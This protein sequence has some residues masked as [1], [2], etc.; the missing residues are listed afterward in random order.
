[1]ARAA[2][3]RELY[4]ARA[5]DYN[6]GMGVGW[7]NEMRTRLFARAQGDVLELGVGTGA[8]FAHYPRDLHSLTGLDVSARMLDLARAHAVELE[9]PVDLQVLDFEHLPFPDD[10]FDTLAASLALCGA[11]DQPA[12]FRELR[13]VLRPGGQLLAFEHVRPPNALLGLVADGVSPLTDHFIGCRMNQRTPE[14]LRAAGFQ[15]GVLERRMLGVF[16][17]LVAR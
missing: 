15:V 5:H 2:R 12:L 9:L 11:P 17:A 7:V 8:T 4:D 10:S 13:R 1:M 16:V 14:T 3:V 6:A